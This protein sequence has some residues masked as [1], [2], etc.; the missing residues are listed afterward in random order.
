MTAVS[1]DMSDEPFLLMAFLAGRDW[2]CSWRAL[3]VGDC[4]LIEFAK[5][6]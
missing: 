5:D 3:N 1:L 4:S 2:C 6:E